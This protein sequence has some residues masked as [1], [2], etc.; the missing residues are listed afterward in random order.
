MVQG[1]RQRTCV[2]CRTSDTKKD[3]LRIVRSPEG[4]VDFD[5]TG[6]A[7]GRGAYVCSLACFEKAMKTKRFDS[8]LRTK[9]T[10]EDYERIARQLRAAFCDK[11]N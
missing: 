10:D 8:A 11:E 9:L 7:N 6:K 5:P 2:V 4:V 3:L 1:K